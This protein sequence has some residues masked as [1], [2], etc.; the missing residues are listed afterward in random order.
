[1]SKCPKCES[2]ISRFKM[3][4]VKAQRPGYTSL[5]NCMAFSCPRCGTVISVE[6]DQTT[7]RDE[8]LDGV[9]SLL[10]SR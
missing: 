4:P 1:M 5:W 10:R 3:E 7:I 8:I 2:A 9:K 6:V